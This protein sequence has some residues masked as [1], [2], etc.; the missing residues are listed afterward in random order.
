MLVQELIDVLKAL[1][2]DAEV[3]ICV[4]GNMRDTRMRATLWHPV[5]TAL[6]GYIRGPSGRFIAKLPKPSLKPTPGLIVSLETDV[7]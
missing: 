4:P 1:P 3:R 6:L 5:T 2:P 7:T